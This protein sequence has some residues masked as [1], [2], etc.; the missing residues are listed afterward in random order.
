MC[1]SLGASAQ[2]DTRHQSQFILKLNT[3]I[4]DQPVILS[5]G[6]EHAEIE[7]RYING[8]MIAL[9]VYK[10]KEYTLTINGGEKLTFVLNEQTNTFSNDF[11]IIAAVIQN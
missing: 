1:I 10:D 3:Q 9:Y 7:R 2:T 6:D 4:D 8:R 5:L 11:E